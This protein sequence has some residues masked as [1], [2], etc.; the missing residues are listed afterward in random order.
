METETTEN[1][2]NEIPSVTCKYPGC[3]KVLVGA[4]CAGQLTG[5]MKTHKARER[6]DNPSKDR[7]E[8]VPMG[9]P[10][11]KLSC[12]SDDGFHYH[13][14]ND[15]W[16]KEPGRI[17]RALRGGYEIVENYEPVPV[18]TNDDGSGIIG[19]LMKLSHEFYDEDQKAK[20]KEVDKVDKQIMAGTLQAGA[21]DKRYSPAGIRIWSGKDEPK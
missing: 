10:E 20:Q 1:Q 2:E 8:R 15:N 3:G 12:P 11:K 16:Q 14:F 7:E 4:N 9:L 21:D 13:V 18:G 5:H 19:I 17:Q 6:S